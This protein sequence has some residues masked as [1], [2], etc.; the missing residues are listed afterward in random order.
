[1]NGWVFFNNLMFG[2][3]TGLTMGFLKSSH[4]TDTNQPAYITAWHVGNVAGWATVVFTLLYL[5]G[6]IK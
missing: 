1:M 3:I 6:F 4:Y 2:Y 5:Y